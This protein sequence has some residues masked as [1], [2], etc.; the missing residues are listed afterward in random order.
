MYLTAMTKDHSA[1]ILH[2]R[3]YAD[4]VTAQRATV[5]TMLFG[6]ERWLDQYPREWETTVG[7]QIRQ[8]KAELEAWLQANSLS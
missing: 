2:W 7:Y 8:I 1:A 6:C 5:T 3:R 4:L